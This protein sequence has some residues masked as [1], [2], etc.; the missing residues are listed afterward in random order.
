MGLGK[1]GPAVQ[2]PV[3][4]SVP[5]IEIQRPDAY[6]IPATKPEVSGILYRLQI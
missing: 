3:F 2:V 4:Y 6:W 5:A 1:P